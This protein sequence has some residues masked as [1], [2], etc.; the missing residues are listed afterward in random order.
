MSKSYVSQGVGLIIDER[1]SSKAKTISY[2]NIACVTAI[3][4]SR[5][6]TGTLNLSISKKDLFDKPLTTEK[7]TVSCDQLTQNNTSCYVG[8]VIACYQ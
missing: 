5:R 8:D 3:V 4:G 7:K 1:Y 2:K 6:T